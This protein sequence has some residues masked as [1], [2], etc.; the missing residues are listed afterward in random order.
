MTTGKKLRRIYSKDVEG[1]QI[2]SLSITYND[3][4]KNKNYFN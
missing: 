1:Y 4:V 2:T 3:E